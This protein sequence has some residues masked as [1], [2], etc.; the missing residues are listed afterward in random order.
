MFLYR[1]FFLYQH[2][3]TVVVSLS[4]F[5]VFFLP[6]SITF[7]SASLILLLHYFRPWD[8]TCYFS[9]RNV[10]ELK[11]VLAILQPLGLSFTFISLFFLPY[12]FYCPLP[13]ILKNGNNNFIAILSAT[14]GILLVKFLFLFFF[15]IFFRL[16]MQLNLYFIQIFFFKLDNL[17]FTSSISCIS[18]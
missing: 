11:D 1:T 13:Y 8:I 16:S 6:L 5:I 17:F 4:Y 9:S 10:L 14:L 3:D 7:C 15:K 18:E 2:L 12:Y